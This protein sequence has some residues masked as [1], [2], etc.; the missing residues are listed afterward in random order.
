MPREVEKRF[1]VK[2]VILTKLNYRLSQ[3]SRYIILMLD[4]AGCH[5]WSLKEK[6]SNI[7]MLFLPPNTTSQLQPLDLG[8]IQNFKVHYRNFLLR[9]VLGK[10]DEC[11]TTSEVVN[12]VNILIAIRW[13]AQAWSLVKPETINRCF[14]KA[15]I[16]DRGMEVVSRGDEQDPFLEI[17]ELQTMID[18]AM[19]VDS[20][21]SLHEYVSGE[22]DVPICFNISGDKW[23]D[24]FIS[25]IGDER[26][27]LDEKQD[28]D[29]DDE[30]NEVAQHLPTNVQ[31]YSQA[32]HALE[33]VQRF[34]E[35]KGHVNDALRIGS[36]VDSVISIKIS[37]QTQ[38]TLHQF[39][40]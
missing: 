34:L 10:I 32:L 33:D 16:L 6:F 13:V 19:G 3:N 8:I 1:N 30:E 9:Y 22:N 31:S 18:R 14:R 5:P 36:V 25:Q 15:G 40:N 17:D 7:K 29:Q 4:N 27:V 23:E 24:E 37:E 2:M 11:D 38:T 28:E 35:H 39:F 26:H 20:G 21:C 12:S